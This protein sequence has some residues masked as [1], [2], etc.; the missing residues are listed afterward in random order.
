MPCAEGLFLKLQKLTADIIWQ[1]VSPVIHW[2]SKTKRIKEIKNGCIAFG[3]KRFTRIPAMNRP[4][5]VFTC[6]YCSDT[7]SAYTYCSEAFCVQ[8]KRE[9]MQSEYGLPWNPFWH[10]D[11]KCNDIGGIAARRFLF[12]VQQDIRHT[13]AAGPKY[14]LHSIRYLLQEHACEASRRVHYL[15]LIHI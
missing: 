10:F 7:F 4:A 5:P 15:S 11:V 6:E 1:T 8:Y 3:D 9:S 13:S 14:V 12:C 2:L